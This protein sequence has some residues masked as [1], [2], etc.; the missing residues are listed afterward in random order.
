MKL[1]GSNRSFPRSCRGRIQL[2]A[3][4]PS[5]HLRP[6]GY[7]RNCCQGTDGP[8]LEFSALAS[9]PTL[10]ACFSRCPGSPFRDDR[11]EADSYSERLTLPRS[12]FRVYRVGWRKLRPVLK[13]GPRSLTC[14][15][16][17]GLSKPTGTVKANGC[18]LSRRGE[19]GLSRG[20]GRIPAV[21]NRPRS[22]GT[23]GV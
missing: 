20:A 19:A 16:V 14:V 15:R 9:R 4:R 17:S 5:V 21:S 1:C 11:P 3:S 22:L 18:S 23:G 12:A 8:G 13:H 10:S 6:V 7:G 2:W